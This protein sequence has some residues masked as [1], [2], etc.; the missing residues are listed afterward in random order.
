MR[1][2]E[3]YCSGKCREIRNARKRRQE[4]SDMKD[5]APPACTPETAYMPETEA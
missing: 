2:T 5:A 1:T 4:R 3:L